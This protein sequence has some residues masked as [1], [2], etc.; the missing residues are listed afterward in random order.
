MWLRHRR[1]DCRG[2]LGHLGNK[3]VKVLSGGMATGILVEFSDTYNE[4]CT[5][6]IKGKHRSC[7][8]PTRIEPCQSW[9]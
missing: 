7:S 3:S 4:P 5:A 1:G 9:S 8:N 6:C 2:I